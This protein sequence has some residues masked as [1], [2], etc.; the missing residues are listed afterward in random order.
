LEDII[1]MLPTPRQC[2]S[3]HQED[4]AFLAAQRE[5][6]EVPMAGVDKIACSVSV[7]KS[8]SKQSLQQES[9]PVLLLNMMSWFFV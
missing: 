6:G 8:K 7:G 5:K 1:P 9:K 3:D 2:S 4:R